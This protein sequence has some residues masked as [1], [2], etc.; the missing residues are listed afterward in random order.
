ML[1]KC[2][3][4]GRTVNHSRAGNPF[5]HKTETT[6]VWCEPDYHVPTP[7][8]DPATTVEETTR[9]DDMSGKGPWFSA[10]YTSE[11][12]GCDGAI[13][14]GHTIRANGQG[15]YECERCVLTEAYDYPDRPAVMPPDWQAQASA[16]AKRHVAAQAGDTPYVALLKEELRAPAPA[17]DTFEDPS[18]RAEPKPVFNVSGQ[19]AAERDWMGRYLVVDPELGDFRRAKN[20]NAL[21]ITRT[22]TFVKAASDNKAI[23]DWGKRNVVIGASRRRDLIL[24][25]VGLTHEDDRDRLD[26][27]VRELE[28][29]AGAKVGSDLGTFLHEFTEFM[30]AGVKTWVDAP[31]E[32]RESLKKYA[33]VLDD[34]G[35]EPVPGLIER[36]VM[37]SEFG[38]VC[39]TFDRVFF[40]RPS[41]TYVIGDLKTGKTLRYG[42]DEFCAQLWN[43]AH[44]INQNGV[45]DWNTNTWRPLAHDAGVR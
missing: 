33:R 34:A 1:G 36:T 42:V 29:A 18:P 20:G 37:I 41:G 7:V 21:G 30:D 40:H 8:S 13:Y 17:A 25:A 39:G 11:C 32:F 28:S 2:V 22:T 14:E 16:A 27:L 5:R 23:N 4:G 15:G 24:K 45:Y 12:A 26:G 43:Y 6:K 38:G 3:R 31:E 35:L 9:G 44:G 10:K 19:P